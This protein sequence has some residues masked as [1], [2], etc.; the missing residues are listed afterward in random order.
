MFVDDLCHLFDCAIIDIQYDI[1]EPSEGRLLDWRPYRLDGAR[2]A[3]Q[4]TDAVGRGFNALLMDIT[5]AVLAAIALSNQN[6]H[7]FTSGK[8]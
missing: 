5:A 7:Q 3:R 1:T 8:A 4:M 2:T 6:R